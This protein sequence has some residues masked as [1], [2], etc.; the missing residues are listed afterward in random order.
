MA[1]KNISIYDNYLDPRDFKKIQ[2]VM[3]DDPSFTWTWCEHS[4]RDQFQDDG[5]LLPNN[6]Q[7]VH[8][9]MN[10]ENLSKLSG[11][12]MDMVIPCFFLT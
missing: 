10:N 8:I 9:F 3:M 5:T 1:N 12:D 11:D 6:Y 4:V 7:Y 2:S